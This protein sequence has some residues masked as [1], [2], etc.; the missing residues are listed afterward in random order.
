MSSVLTDQ[1][2]AKQNLTVRVSPELMQGIKTIRRRANKIGKS[3]DASAIAE[4]ALRDAVKTADKELAKLEQGEGAKEAKSQPKPQPEKKP[5]Q[6]QESSVKPA[7]PDS[8]AQAQR[9]QN[10][11]R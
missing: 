3:F 4:K 8:S 7:Q 2:S 9:P 6:T 11:N 5:E 1:S 10:P